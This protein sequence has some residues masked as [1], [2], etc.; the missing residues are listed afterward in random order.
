[1]TQADQITLVRR[2][3]APGRAPWGADLGLIL[4]PL[5]VVFAAIMAFGAASPPLALAWV[6]AQ[7]LCAGV[8]TIGFVRRANKPRLPGLQLA[9]LVLFLVLLVWS[10]LTLT[11]VPGFAI[12]EAWN[13]I[14]TPGALTIDRGAT[15]V[16]ILK[17]G[18]LACAFFAA[19]LIGQDE[20]RAE[21]TLT[22]VI[23][24][25][26][27]Y[28]LWAIVAFGTDN[29]TVLSVAKSYHLQRLTGSFFS[30]NSAGAL[31]GLL[32]V[33]AW[34]TALRAIRQHLQTAPDA[35]PRR[36]LIWIAVRAAAAILLWG[37]LLLTVSRA[38]MVSTLACLLLVTAL[39][40]VEGLG[41]A[42]AGLGKI[43]GYTAPALLAMLVIFAATIGEQFVGELAD[44]GS[45]SATRE[46]I[47]AAYWDVARHAPLAGY[48]LG[49]FP[50]LN[51]AQ[52][53]A[54]NFDALWNLGAVHNI[55]LQWLIEGGVIGA[56]LMAAVMI[57]ILVDIARRRVGAR[58]G[59]TR[60]TIAL[61]VSALLLLHN[62]VDYSIQVPAIAALWAFLLGLGAAPGASG[63]RRTGSSGRHRRPEQNELDSQPASGIANPRS[64]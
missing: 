13:A 52:V 58:A 44:L 62:T 32:S 4:P 21:R 43:I 37:A 53:T 50:S 40:I 25:G 19:W 49:A 35:R 56:G 45:D 34:I 64:H 60:A 1:M 2:Q 57:L 38:A 29:A 46:T 14:E 33:V 8:L 9:A 26:V 16:E 28:A 23:V 3:S 30:A 41:R 36:S 5:A 39:E 10:A 17:L 61:A 11:A 20:L 24:L 27:A 54:E 7:A 18:G 48:G 63:T 51:L 6:T 59:R 47:F 55:Y 31:F 22:I 12:P 15:L 42:R